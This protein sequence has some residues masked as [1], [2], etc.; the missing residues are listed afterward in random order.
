L[1]ETNIPLD[2]DSFVFYRSFYEAIKKLKDR[3][4][5]AAYNAICNYA[6]NGEDISEDGS[7][8]AV[9]CLIKPLID[10]NNKRYENGKK[11]G[12][13]AKAETEKKP[14]RN[15]TK[16][17]SKPN[18]Y[19]NDNVNAN[20]ENVNTSFFLSIEEKTAIVEKPVENPDDRLRDKP[21]WFKKMIAE[22]DRMQVSPETTDAVGGIIKCRGQRGDYDG[23]GDG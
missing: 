17:T 22:R 8:A 10:A 3:D 16:T 12:R 6:L 14:K 23:E 7:A 9:Y 15:Q 13:P 20:E 11:G 5:L 2:R 4:K 1:S 18:V 21:E 19:V